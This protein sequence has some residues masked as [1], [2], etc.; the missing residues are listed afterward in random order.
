MFILDQIAVGMEL[1]DTITASIPY[2][3][4]NGPAYPFSLAD[5]AVKITEP[6]LVH[7][8]GRREN[9]WRR[10]VVPFEMASALANK[11]GR[12]FPVRGPALGLFL[13]LEVRMVNGPI[14]ADHDCVLR[15]KVVGL[16]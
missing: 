13:D 14:F 3:E 11:S 1:P 6:H 7:A 2:E 10:I 8:G 12:G 9:P 4:A 5:K 15:R 16:G